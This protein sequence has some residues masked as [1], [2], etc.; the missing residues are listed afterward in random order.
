MKTNP[1]LTLTLALL[2]GAAALTAVAQTAPTVPIARSAAITAEPK[3]E[4]GGFAFAV[5]QQAYPG[6]DQQAGGAIALP[7]FVYRGEILRADRGN[8]GL[9]AFKS[10]EFEFDLGAGASLGSN[11]R[12]IEARLGMPDL[13]TLIEFGPRLKWKF[14]AADA[15]PGSRGWQLELPLRGVFDLSDGFASRGVAFEPE[16]QYSRRSQSGWT[17]SASVGAVFGS[18]RLTE[19]FYAVAP[20]YATAARPAYEARAGLVAWR[21]GLNV[22]RPLS[23]DWRLFVFGRIDSVAGAANANSPLVKRNTGASAGIG[24]S[25]TWMRSSERAAD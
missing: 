4:L 10:A 20:A 12:D 7:F 5:S 18:R 8:L 23:A 21:L 9:R 2:G 25:W 15:A 3:W 19:H 22:V 14:G 11:S 16:L 6:A 1:A 13:G 24:L 17:T